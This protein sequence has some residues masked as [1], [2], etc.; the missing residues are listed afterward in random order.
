MLANLP[1]NFLPLLSAKKFLD[2]MAAHARKLEHCPD[3]G[4]ALVEHRTA[5]LFCDGISR[6]IPLPF[7]GRCDSQSFP[8]S[9]WA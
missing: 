5:T 2:T 7:C 8:T 9:E 4:S 6:D 1:P 3:C